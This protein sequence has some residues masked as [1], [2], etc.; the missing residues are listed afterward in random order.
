MFTVTWDPCS[1]IGGVVI[2]PVPAALAFQQYLGTFRDNAKAAWMSSALLFVISGVAFVVLAAHV[3]EM[4]VRGVQ[5]PRMSP[6][7]PMLAT[8]VFSGTSAWVNLSWSRRL[9]RSST[10][11]DHSAARIRVSF[12]E[13]LVGVTAI[14]CVTAPASYFA[15][16]SPS[17]YAEN[18]SRD[19][20]PFGL[21]AA[22]IEISFC[23]GQRGTIAFEFTIDEKSFVEWVESGI[24]S[25]ESQAAN[26]PLQPITGPYSIRRYSSLT[27]ELS[28]PELVTIT[29]GLYYD[30][31]EE[32]RGVY[33]A[34]DRTTNRA[35]Y[36]AHF[37]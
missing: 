11:N 7:V 23:Q 20:A 19:E 28:G 21:P 24:G 6:V 22:A 5:S 4:I 25:F 10:T 8:V 37:H 33:A 30:W 27:S 34:F 2:L 18:V 16:T 26:V 35:Y 31:S 3:G 9:R 12:R 36:F 15:R 29:N 1:F 32:D 14:A 13:L 17:R